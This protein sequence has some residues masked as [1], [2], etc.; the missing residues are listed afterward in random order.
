MDL[1]LTGRISESGLVKE[2]KKTGGLNPA[3]V[4]SLVFRLT[5][6]ALVFGF[7]VMLARLMGEK[8]YGHYTVIITVLNVMLMVSTFG[9]DFSAQRIVPDCIAKGDHS[10]ANGFASFSFRLI[11]VF[12]IVCSVSVFIFLLFISK[13]F[14]ISFSEGMFWGIL[15][16]PFLACI[17]QASA[18]L[19]SVNRI[20]SSLIAAYYAFPVM[21]GIGCIYYYNSHS[22]LGVDAVM[23]INLVCGALICYFVVR[24]SR[25]KLIE[26]A[27]SE[28]ESISGRKWMSGSGLLFTAFLPELLMRQTD[29][30]MVSYYLDNG[31]AGQYAVAAR[32]A[33]MVA[34]GL[35]ITDQVYLQKIASYLAS[36]QLLKLQQVVRNA[37]LQALSIAMPVGFLLIVFGSWLLGFFGD[38]YA[39]AFFPLV[40]LIAGQL[41]LTATGM[42]GSLMKMMGYKKIFFAF[43][44]LALLAQLFLNRILIHVYGITGAAIGTTV[45][46]IL[47]NVFAY[48]FIK[49][50]TKIRASFL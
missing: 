32:L 18:L 20:K 16:L 19:R 22:K 3:V 39:S 7:Q 40:I 35:A 49:R 17:A 9:L 38:F 10:S 4:R 44:I 31:H 26:I 37:S 46:L 14:S 33:T 13:R 1:F 21:T 29:I 43:G 8:H 50:R 2:F 5:G 36:K 6:L 15:L 25:K 30:L 42:A 23:L 12:A 45:S 11:K 47:L 27:P 34:L 48:L 28:K 24:H 41:I